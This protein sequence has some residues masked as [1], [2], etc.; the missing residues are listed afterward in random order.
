MVLI[1][2]L[3]YLLHETLTL[4]SAFPVENFL[5]GGGVHQLVNKLETKKNVK[6]QSNIFNGM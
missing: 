4:S 2:F 1:H 6:M 5:G 3:P